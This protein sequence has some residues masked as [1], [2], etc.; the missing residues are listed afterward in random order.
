VAPAAASSARLVRGRAGLA[1][2][3][4]GIVG[5]PQELEAA[6]PASRPAMAARESRATDEA[7][8]AR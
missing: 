7:G 5:R 2:D 1:G 8:A 4:H 3:R 6:N